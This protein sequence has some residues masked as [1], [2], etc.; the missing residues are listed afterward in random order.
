[1]SQTNSKLPTS[2]KPT[3]APEARDPVNCPNCKWWAKPGLERP[4]EAFRMLLCEWDVEEGREIIQAKP[5]M[6]AQVPV[7]HVRGLVNWPPTPDGSLDL[8]KIAVVAQHVPHVDHSEPCLVGYYPLEVPF[9]KPAKAGKKKPPPAADNKRRTVFLDGHHRICRAIDLKLK[10]LDVYVLAPEESDWICRIGGGTRVGKE[11]PFPP[12][13]RNN[14]ISE[15]TQFIKRLKK[16][17]TDEERTDALACL[18]E[19]ICLHCGKVLEDRPCFC[20]RD[21]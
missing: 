16:F 9:V 17:K 18:G 13:H 1:M 2:I 10:T 11:N 4:H 19:E 6:K 7:E 5:R 12:G 3:N 14:P 21:D 15:L 20:T 8:L